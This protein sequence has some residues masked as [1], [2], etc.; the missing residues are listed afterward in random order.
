MI[1]LCSQC[2]QKS[3]ENLVRELLLVMNIIVDVE[4]EVEVEVVM[5]VSE[6]L[7]RLVLSKFNPFS[8]TKKF[9]GM[10]P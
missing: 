8:Q 4:V 5:D 7:R 6:T 3:Q 2:L 10:I 1:R 9:T